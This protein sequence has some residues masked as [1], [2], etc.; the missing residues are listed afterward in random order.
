MTGAVDARARRRVAAGL[1]IG[2][3]AVFV[4]NGREIGAGDTVPG[5]L[6]P[7]AV[8]RGDGLDLGRFTHLWPIWAGAFDGGRHPYFVSVTDGRTRSRYPVAPALLALPL[9]A[10]QLAVADRRGG[11]DW[12]RDD[13]RALAL[14]S[15]MAKNSAA[16]LTAL[17]GVALY[18]LLYRIGC[19]SV[20]VAATV[21]TLLGSNLWMTAS[22]SPWQHGG[23]A[24]ALTVTLLL[25]A[26]PRPGRGELAAAGAAL[27]MLVCCRLQNAILAAVI[28]LAVVAWQGRRAVWFLPGAALLVALLLG[29]NLREFGSPVG[30]YAELEGVLVRAHAVAGPWGT[31]PWWDG[32]AGT[33][34]SPSRGLLVF[35]PWV[36]VAVA[37]L[38][39]TWP[40]LRPF[41]ALRA[42]AAALVPH[43]VLVSMIS[44]WW[45]GWSFG[46]RYWTDVMPVFGL[47]LGLA[48]AW[49][50]QRARPLLV[51]AGAA[52]ALAIAI[53]A[54]GAFTFPSTWNSAPANVNVAP[55]R[56]W[57]WR[58]SELT[59]ALYEGPHPWTPGQVARQLTLTPPR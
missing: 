52:G 34:F 50:A 18:L 16:A 21:I 30:G 13:H 51:V 4:V 53:Q 44:T 27:G 41:P 1:W 14:V 26:T 6:L 3:F 55:A 54:L 57:D 19:A 9:V 35:S 32:I 59:R 58:D 28:G 49:A 20:A 10:P 40:R 39:A 47:L 38:P 8:L 45:A 48:L 42:S 2:L 37:A 25:L 7:V 17:T 5:M 11:P 15:A 24:L 31:D 22:Q 43:L 23:A 33:L 46:P 12:E 36:I 56:L 29:W